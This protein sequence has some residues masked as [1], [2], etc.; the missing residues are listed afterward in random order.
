LLQLPKETLRGSVLE[1]QQRAHSPQLAA[2]SSKS[3]KKV[4]QTNTFYT[5][6][7]SGSIKHAFWISYQ[8]WKDEK[9]KT[10][11]KTRMAVSVLITCMSLCSMAYAFNGGRGQRSC[12][13]AHRFEL[14]SQLPAEK[15]ML[16]HQTMRDSREKGATWRSEIRGLREEIKAII[17]ATQ[18]DEGL[19][20]EKVDRLE[21][22][23]MKRRATMEDAIVT[24]AKEF[25]PD[26]R[27]IL[28][29]LLPGKMARGLH[30]A[31][32]RKQ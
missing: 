10:N 22:L 14:L 28:V 8:S 18:F 3:K 4:K 30:A 9:E 20:R 25:T 12:N 32:P 13:K 19:F 16:F 15:E 17:V 29:Q 1:P 7:V 2:E 11:M 6:F 5:S 31:G 23:Q 21:A 27:K 24:L 26:E